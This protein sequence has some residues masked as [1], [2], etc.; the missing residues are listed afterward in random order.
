M[1]YAATAAILLKIAISEYLTTSIFEVDGNINAHAI[2]NI[3]Q[4]HDAP[5]AGH[6]FNKIRSKWIDCIPISLYT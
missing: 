6:A 2:R 1:S 3:D 4:M 5:A